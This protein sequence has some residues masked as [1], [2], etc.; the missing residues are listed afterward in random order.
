MAKRA[1]RSYRYTLHSRY[2]EAIL[3]GG[4]GDRV[5]LR[6]YSNLAVRGFHFPFSGISRIREALK[7][8]FRP[9]LGNASQ[10]VSLIP[11]FAKNDRRSSDGCAFLLFGG[12]IE[13]K[14]LSSAARNDLIWPL[15]VVFAGRIGGAGLIVVTD[16]DISSALWMDDWVPKYYATMRTSESSSEEL[17]RSAQ[18]YAV[19]LGNEIT[20]ICNIDIA[21]LSDDEI[22]AAGD[23]T[24]RAHPQMASLDLSNKGMDMLEMRERIISSLTW[25]GRAM[26]ATGALM[27]MMIGA[28]WFHHTSLLDRA[29][30]STRQV[31]QK[32]FG[33][34]SSQPLSSAR[35]KLRAVSSGEARD[36]SLLEISRSFSSAW[37][38]LGASPDIV[39]DSVRYGP[40]NIDI[41]GT[42]AG[43]EQIQRLRSIL[44]EDGYTVRVDNIQRIPNGDL[45]FNMSIVRGAKE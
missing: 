17:V 14:S 3:E 2:P 25:F 6:S 15:P 21:D 8:S 44:D 20:E 1:L 4:Q 29:D 33:E 5:F 16:G 28:L 9:L 11:F 45:R 24:M 39:M 18:M 34:Q 43:N 13:D 23:Q 41:T 19:S 30:G 27:L 37:D 42:S 26:A 32:A 40:E 10:Q 22:Q 38:I 12:E 36:I 7:L 31:Y 35:A